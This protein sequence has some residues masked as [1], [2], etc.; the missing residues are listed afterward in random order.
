[1]FFSEHVSN[2]YPEELCETLL[3]TV[4]IRQIGILLGKCGEWS[5]RVKKVE[6]IVGV[7]DLTFSEDL[8]FSFIRIKQLLI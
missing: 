1:M 3:V 2:R 4:I 5:A 6:P 7:G 8:I